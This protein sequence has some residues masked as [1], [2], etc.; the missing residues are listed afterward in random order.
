[1]KRLRDSEDLSIETILYRRDIITCR[2][3]MRDV[4]CVYAAI[5]ID[6]W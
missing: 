3:V 4:M 6:E 2:G 1:M 5:Q